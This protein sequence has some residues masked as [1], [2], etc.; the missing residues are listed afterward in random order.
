MDLNDDVI[1]LRDLARDVPD[2]DP[3]DG[4]TF[5]WGGA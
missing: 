2:R 1:D 4:R 3:F 5:Y